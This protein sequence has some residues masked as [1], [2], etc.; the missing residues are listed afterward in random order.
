MPWLSNQD[1]ISYAPSI[2]LTGEPL[3]TAI[4]LAQSLVEGVNGSNRPLALTEFTKILS[5]P[6]TGRVIV[7]IRP[8]L[9]SPAPVIELRGS[10]TPP[11]F[12][13]YS[14]QEWELL[15]LDKDYIIDYDNNEVGLLSLS[16]VLRHEYFYHVGFRRY[17]RSPTVPRIKKQ[18]KVT[19]YSGFNF[20]SNAEEVVT[21]KRALASIVAIRT[22]PQSQGVKSVDVSDEKYKVEY[23]SQSDYLGISGNK[24]SGSPINELLSIFRKYRPS[25]YTS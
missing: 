7:P 12:G 14:L 10:D 22:S 9:P 5:I 16:R 18:L 11:R 13:V 8:L 17:S 20:T 19:Y 25:E 21:L 2:T 15:T 4:T 23:A 6:N 1:C 24:T 3:T